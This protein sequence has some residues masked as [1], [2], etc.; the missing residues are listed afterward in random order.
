MNAKQSRKDTLKEVFIGMFIGLIGNW[1]ITASVI[2]TGM[3]AVKA[4]TLITVLCTIWSFAR[5]YTL[6]RFFN[7]RVG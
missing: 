1:M 7:N 6:R 5:G 2:S 4:A 3:T